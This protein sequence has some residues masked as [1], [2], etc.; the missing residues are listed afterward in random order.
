MIISAIYGYLF[1]DNLAWRRACG[2]VAL[3]GAA[4]FGLR[5]LWLPESLAAVGVEAMAGL[6]LYAVLFIRFG[7]SA[8]ERAMV[9]SLARRRTRG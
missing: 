3:S 9:W 4:L 8:S 1:F 7:M 6:A 2:R 5:A